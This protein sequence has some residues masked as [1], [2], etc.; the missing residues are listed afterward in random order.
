MEVEKEGKKVEDKQK[1]RISWEDVYLHPL[2]REELRQVA[3]EV[4]GRN[5]LMDI[6]NK[7]TEKSINIVKVL[8]QH[9][10]EHYEFV[11]KQKIL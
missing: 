5:I 9:S 3:R 1:S 2:F 8:E 11:R 6:K 4:G 7:A 10:A